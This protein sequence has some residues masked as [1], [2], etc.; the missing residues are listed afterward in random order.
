M[1]QKAHFF[2]FSIYIKNINQSINMYNILA[3]WPTHRL[4]VEIATIW[5]G[6]KMKKKWAEGPLFWPTPISESQKSHL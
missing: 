6:P 4:F 2:L 1:G 5:G 3:L